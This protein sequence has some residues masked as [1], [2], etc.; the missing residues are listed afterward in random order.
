MLLR[1]EPEELDF[2]GVPPQTQTLQLSN[3][4][5]GSRETVVAYKVRTTAPQRFSVTP[6][7]GLLKPGERIDVRG[8]REAVALISRASVV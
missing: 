5:G 1:C 4:V 8:T 6:V 3:A 7:I 2:T